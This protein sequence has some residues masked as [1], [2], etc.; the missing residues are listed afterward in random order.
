MPRRSILVAT[1]NKKA[2]ELLTAYFADTQ[3]IP[4][5]IRSPADCADFLSKAELD[6]I[7][8]DPDWIDERNLGQ[9]KGLK[10]K[11][12]SSKWLALGHPKVHQ[13]P[14]DAEIELPIDEKQFQKIIFS[15][16]AFPK[17]IKLMVVD[18]EADIIETIRDYFEVRKDPEFEVR[19]AVNGLEG[20]KRIKEDEPHCLILDIK[21]PV[22]TGVELYR[23][24]V[25]S[26]RKIP[27]VIFIDSTAAEDT[28]EIRKF[29]SPAFVEKGG[30]HSSMPEMLNL[31]RKLVAFS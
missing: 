18:D 26:G 19:S 21:M 6:F 27:T 3:S 22:R 8:L 16:V 23:D 29:G 1:G 17:R 28:L 14:W 24:L 11:N 30:N 5:V 7:F 4:A 20:F 2:V 12:P 13:F 9:F 25:Q 15:H 10:S 31:V